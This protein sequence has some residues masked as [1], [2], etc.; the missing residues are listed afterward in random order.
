M[1]AN[2]GI[3]ELA[4]GDAGPG[5]EGVGIDAAGVGLE[6]GIEKPELDGGEDGGGDSIAVEKE[7]AGGWEAVMSKEEGD[8]NKHGHRGA[9]ADGGG[10]IAAGCAE[11]SPGE[12]A[13]ADEDENQ[14]DGSAVFDAVV[15]CRTSPCRPGRTRRHPWRCGPVPVCATVRPRP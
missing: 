11:V 12:V 10:A 7:G 5:D 4:A 6:G 8:E 15:D 3:V 13:G 1:P 2:E 9:E 14:N